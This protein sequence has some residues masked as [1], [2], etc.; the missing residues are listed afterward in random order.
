LV[1]RFNLFVGYQRCIGDEVPQF[2]AY[3]VHSNSILEF[4]DGHAIL[5]Q[6]GFIT[7]EEKA[8]VLYKIG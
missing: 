6:D 1:V 5:A 7:V 4:L 3:D 8:S 2:F